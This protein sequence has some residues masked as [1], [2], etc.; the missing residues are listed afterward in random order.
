MLVYQAE[1]GVQ[2]VD[3]A[4][5]R[6]TIA[7]M[8]R[9]LA[10]VGATGRVQQSGHR[11]IT[12][13]LSA[14]SGSTA[15]AVVGKTAQLLF[16][17]WEPNVI[18]SHGKP[19]PKETTATGGPQAG[20]PEFGLPQYQAVKRAMA[21][22]PELRADDTTW[23]PGCTA[24]QA[25][26]C[27][28]GSWY[29]LEPR[30]EKVLRGPD[31]TKAELY[32]DFTAQQAGGLEAVHVNPGTVVVRARAAETQ[33]GEITEQTPD[34]FFVLRDEPALDG[35]EIE[36]PQQAFEEGAGGSGAPN[37]VFSFTKR[38]EHAF[39]RL[40]R[41]VAHRGE[42]AQLPGVPREATLQHFATV[43]D[44]QLTSNPSIN[45]VHYPDGIDGSIGSEIDG[46]FTLRSARELVD[47]LKAGALP[48]QLLLIA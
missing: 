5:L 9:R 40:T 24:R 42:E 48:L 12:V 17:D 43:L 13:T 32:S 33:S 8:R 31:E 25:R 45:Y 28:Y 21:R 29:L 34:S 27:A 19:A 22:A 18:G 3:S 26:A 47:E 1:N 37:V 36:H 16:Y 35:S 10:A 7:I 46:A 11:R 23:S 6:Q 41:A 2:P 4:S 20:A 30:H 15:E 44:G 38:G 14:A 39:E